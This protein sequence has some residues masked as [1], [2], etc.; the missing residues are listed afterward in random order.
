MAGKIPEPAFR[1]QFGREGWADL[2]PAVYALQASGVPDCSAVAA[3]RQRR[4]PRCAINL[5]PKWRS[6]DG[7]G[8]SGVDH[9]DL[10]RPLIVKWVAYNNFKQVAD[11]EIA[12]CLRIVLR[13]AEFIC[14]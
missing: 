6:E 9:E 4:L 14:S 1:T 10:A 5:A 7:S 8:L 11:V 3:S 12:R 13:I 2:S